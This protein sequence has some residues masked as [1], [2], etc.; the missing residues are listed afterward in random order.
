LVSRCRKR[1]VGVKKGGILLPA[2]W[3]SVIIFSK[4]G[5][6]EQGK[7]GNSS[8][9]QKNKRSFWKSIFLYGAI[10]LTVFLVTGGF[11]LGSIL[12]QVYEAVAS[13]EEGG[14]SQRDKERD[15]IP[16]MLNVLI[17]GLDSRDQVCRADTIML[18]TLN[19]KTGSINIVSI[20]RDMRVN[21]PGYGLDK[22]NHAYAYGEVAL[23]KEVVEEFLDIHIDHYVTT[24]F[25][26]FVN[27]VDALGG[28][29]LEVEKEM[30][31]KGIDV[32]INL[33]PGYQLLDGEKALQYVR[34]R[35]DA[36]ADLGRVRR[37]QNFIKTLLQEIIAYKNILK[38]PRLL[39]EIAENI[40]TDLE[41]N[42]AIKLANRLKSVEIEEINTFT[43]PGKSGKIA[44]I[45]YILPEEEEIRHLV[46]LHIKG[47]VTEKS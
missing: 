46:D 5:R 8:Q 31:Y 13:E 44:G 42:Q 9:G 27:I 25:D 22:I 38:F 12:E 3:R 1:A 30:I 11:W 2:A 4:P 37:Q 6:K 16:D 29:E 40:K 10:I 20:P 41:L 21:I 33:Q 15:P 28:I 26:G 34:W 35:S 7:M 32:D 39:P 47:I 23:S 17:M 43:L 36:E 18:L 19:N 14:I 45:S 24:D